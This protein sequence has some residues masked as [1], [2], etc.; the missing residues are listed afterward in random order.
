MNE[1]SILLFKIL[2][3]RSIKLPH[4]ISYSIFG[5]KLIIA[6]IF[7]ALEHGFGYGRHRFPIHFYASDP[8]I[9]NKHYGHRKSGKF[10]VNEDKKFTAIFGHRF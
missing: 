5:W 2:N 9:A 1:N 4:I 8:D 3:T 7:L 10:K 6:Y